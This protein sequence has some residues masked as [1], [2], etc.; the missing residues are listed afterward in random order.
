MDTVLKDT[1]AD[2]FI[3]AFEL[4]YNMNGVKHPAERLSINLG[5]NLI[6]GKDSSGAIVNKLDPSAVALLSA[7]AVDEKPP[8]ELALE[9]QILNQSV[10]I[11]IDRFTVLSYCDGVYEEKLLLEQI[12]E[13][14]KL[15][16]AFVAVKDKA[17]AVVLLS[18]NAQ[19][20]VEEANP[21]DVLDFEERLGITVSPTVDEVK[22]VAPQE[23]IIDDVYKSAFVGE[24]ACWE[25]E[26]TPKT[27]QILE[28]ELLKQSRSV[29]V[30]PSTQ[31]EVESKVKFE[32]DAQPIPKLQQQPPTQNSFLSDDEQALVS[33]IVSDHEEAPQT[34]TSVVAV[35]LADNMSINSGASRMFVATA[36][37]NLI[38]AIAETGDADNNDAV[39]AASINL[40]QAKDV[41]LQVD[42]SLR[43]QQAHKLMTT[44][45]AIGM[46]SGKNEIRTKG[47]EYVVQLGSDGSALL[48]S[49]A[50]VIYDGLPNI[51]QASINLMS[52]FDINSLSKSVENTAAY[53]REAEKEKEKQLEI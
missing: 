40:L 36:E 24:Q 53:M 18:T 19:V 21:S 22:E 32:I 25:I 17:I 30:V 34:E 20:G 42:A 41:N 44:I 12:H 49:A 38:T 16:E 48:R 45:V 37:N 23:V 50:G 1:T 10:D 15:K 39:D 5:D 28:E 4:A 26:A 14:E 47:G 9:D 27:L 43:D 6:Y 52:N 8:L 11:Q 13:D 46:A 35:S 7:V 2:S 33:E 29:S 51:K 3:E 31:P